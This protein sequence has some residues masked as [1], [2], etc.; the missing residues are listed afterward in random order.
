MRGPVTKGPYEPPQPWDKKIHLNGITI[1]PGGF[2]AMEGVWRQRAQGADIGD[3]PFGGIPALNS[4]LAH[5]NEMRFSAR[6]SRV[7]ALVQGN[8]NPDILV[9]GYG[10]LDFLGAGNTANTNESNSYNLRIRHMYATVDWQDEGVA[11]SRR[12]ELVAGDLAR[13]GHHAAQ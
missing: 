6:Q 4:P 9:S 1:T 5:M 7:S 12:P 3:V 8:V 10:E 11:C 13:Q 2:F